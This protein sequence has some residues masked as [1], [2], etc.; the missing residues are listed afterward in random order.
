M[1]EMNILDLQRSTITWDQESGSFS[2]LWRCRNCGRYLGKLSGVK[3]GSL[4]APPCRTKTC[5]GY[6]NR[7]G[8]ETFSSP[9][10]DRTD[11]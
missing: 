11:V 8:F 2:G 9:A 5:S 10:G 1:S 4:E 6:V 7:I 3:A